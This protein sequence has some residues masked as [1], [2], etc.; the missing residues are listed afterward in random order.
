MKSYRHI[1]VPDTSQ[2]S[3]FSYFLFSGVGSVAAVA[4]RAATLFWPPKKN[5]S[6]LNIYE[7]VAIHQ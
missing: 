1:S 7:T 3:S 5:Q 4:A 6:L 2:G